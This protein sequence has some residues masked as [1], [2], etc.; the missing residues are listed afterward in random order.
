MKIKATFLDEISYDIPHQNW[1]V[2]EW[3]KDFQ[4]MKAVGI[5]MV[6]LI[7]CGLRRQM[8]FPSEVLKREQ[9][10]FTPSTDLIQMFL[11]LAQKHDM[12][13]CFHYLPPFLRPILYEM[14]TPA[15]VGPI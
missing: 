14:I 8:T 6:V 1:G 2:E 4:A 10:C 13:F 9:S 11:D 3:D 15:F 12:K 5:D 7:R